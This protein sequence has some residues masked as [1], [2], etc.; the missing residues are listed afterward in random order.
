MS[1]ENKSGVNGD[2]QNANV[3]QDIRL[4]LVSAPT[5]SIVSR[6]EAKN[7]LKI[8]T[9]TTDDTLVDTLIATAT[10]IIE[11]EAGGVALCPQTWQQTQTGGCKE[12]TLLRQPVS[13]TPTVSYY[14]D[15]DTTTA[16]NITYSTDF[17]VVAPNR[18]IHADGYFE[19]G[20]D[21]DGYTIRF[22]CSLFTASSYTNS[23]DTRLGIYKTAILRTIAWMYEQREEHVASANEGGWSVNYNAVDL[24]LGIRRLIMPVHTGE[25]IL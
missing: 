20:R 25:G 9:D 23:N 15:F 24:P 3:N 13:G 1:W 6:T 8:G 10:G 2:I 5:L 12:F 22:E 17:K 18:L 16:T 7:Y 11:R 19:K 4:T 14:D 21:G